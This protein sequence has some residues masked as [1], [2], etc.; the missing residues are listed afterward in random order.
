MKMQ[1]ENHNLEQE[2]N[3]LLTSFK[4]GMFLKLEGIFNFL[5]QSLILV[6]V[7][8]I[9][10]LLLWFIPKGAACVVSSNMPILAGAITS[11]ALV[12]LL[13]NPFIGIL[14]GLVAGLILKIPFISQFFCN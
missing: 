3:Q 8:G 7:V 1:S 9:P 10:V 2:N 11:A 6:L 12:L 4:T 5:G 13:G 14:A